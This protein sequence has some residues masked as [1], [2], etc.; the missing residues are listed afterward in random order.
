MLLREG[1]TCLRI[2]FI[3]FTHMFWI[4]SSNR[5]HPFLQAEKGG[6]SKSYKHSGV[7]LELNAPTWISLSQ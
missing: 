6:F 5:I 2:I 4:I 3:N 1:V 7:T